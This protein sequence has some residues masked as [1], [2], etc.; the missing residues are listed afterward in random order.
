[1]NAPLRVSGDAGASAQR[2]YDRRS[3][4]EAARKNKAVADDT[5]WR[6][7]VKAERPVLG[8]LAAAVTAKPV[9]TPESQATKAW[10]TGASGEV[11]VAQV[12]DSCNTVHALHDRRI[13]GSKANIDHIAVT[14]TGVYVIDAKK[15][16]GAI[17]ARNAGGWL[18]EDFRLYVHNRD[19]PKLAEAMVSQV[20]NVRKALGG[21][22]AG[23]PVVPV[24]CFAGCTWAGF[25]P[26][27][28]L[29]R[30]VAILWPLA[31]SD[32]LKRTAGPSTYDPGM[33]AQ[34]IAQTLRPA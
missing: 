16:T 24:L 20:D 7:R 11:R 19:Q 25:R 9:V 8:R 26:K 1:M 17:E 31:L 29:I 10:A 4:R 21:E 6:N 27:P 3:A 15:Y 22:H 14:S 30:G 34:T 13:P 2:E 28:F 18:R 23:I 33:V 32:F 5:E 12:L